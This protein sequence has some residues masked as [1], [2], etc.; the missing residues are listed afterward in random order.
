[1]KLVISCMDRRLNAYL[2]KNY[3][4]A[5][6]VRNAGANLKSLQKTLEKY[7]YSA[8]EVIILPHTDCG[9]MK[10][11]YSS[12]KEGKK[13]TSLVEENLVSQFTN[14]EFNSLTELERL[15]LKIQIENARRIFGDKV[16]GELIDINKIEI[17]P[18]KEPYSVYVTGPSLPL[19]ID[20]NTYVISADKSDIWDSLDIA[21]YGMK[22]NKI[23]VSDEKLLDKIRSSYPSVTVIRSS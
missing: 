4:D 21:V 13:I 16:K 23:L 6:V 15:N 11:V 7:K 18:S 8:T 1:M 2:K 9:A 22:I 20:S 14:S 12:L 3:G 10:V 17:P 19:N 5:I